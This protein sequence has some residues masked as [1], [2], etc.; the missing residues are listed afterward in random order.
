MT[1]A[2]VTRFLIAGPVSYVTLF[3][4]LPILSLLVLAGG[5]GTYVDV[6]Q[7]EHNWSILINTFHLSFVVTIVTLVLGYPVA[8]RARLAGPRMR[9]F[10]LLAATIPLWTSLLARSYAWVSV[11]QRRGLIN[12]VLMEVGLLDQPLRLLNTTIGSVVG[13]AYVFLPLMILTLYAHMS[14]LDLKLLR[15]SRTLGARPAQGFLSIF[16]PLS[17]P[18]VIA[19]SLLVFIVSLGLFVT[20]ALLGGRKDQTLSMLIAQQVQRFGNFS[21][22]AALAILLLVATLAIL[23]GFFAVTGV[24]RASTKERRRKPHSYRWGQIVTPMVRWSRG[25]IDVA[26]SRLVWDTM[27]IGVVVFLFLPLITLLAM[28]FSGTEYLQFPPS[29]LSFRW[30]GALLADSKWVSAATSSVYVAVG[31]S[32]VASVIGLLAALGLRDARPTAGRLC[33]VLYLAPALIPH[34]VY[35]LGAYALGTE[36]ELADTRVGLAVTHSILAIP[37]VVVICYTG[38]REIGPEIDKA[39]RSLGA[40]WFQRVRRVTVPLLSRS[41][42]VSSL[43]AF[44]VSFDEIVVALLFTG[45]ET[46]TFPKVLWQAAILEVTPIVP[47]AASAVL[48]IGSLLAVVGFVSTYIFTPAR[49]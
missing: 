34:M 8:Y 49:K 24:G 35:S 7:K 42:I 47:A 46:R 37:F 15:A 12:S 19:G 31:A 28:S 48:I 45:L 2:T 21:T 25:V 1:Q 43:I 39:A 14:A 4:G 5:W 22:A 3:F 32:V 26:E 13:S 20:P 44:L 17:A 23:A 10:L 27:V 41:L 6:F 18:G 36:V 29:D 11:L 38:L 16:L 9:L 30:Y 33:F 40:G